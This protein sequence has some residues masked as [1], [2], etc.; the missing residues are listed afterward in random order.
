[1]ELP[2]SEHVPVLTGIPEDLT[3]IVFGPPK[4]GKTTFAASFPNS[5]VVECEPGGAKYVKGRIL[6]VKNLAE[7]REA[8]AIVKANPGYCETVVID[9]IDQVAAWIEAEICQE[10]GLKN[11]LDSKKGEKH[12][13]QWGEY[14]DR[15]LSLLSAWKM[16]GKR[17]VYLAHVKKAE[18]DGNALVINPKTI[19]LYG[20][21]AARVISIVENIGHMYAREDSNG[22]SRILSF[23]PG[24]AIEAG[25][26]HP[27]L[28]NKLITIPA[29][30]PYGPFAALFG[31]NG[32]ETKESKTNG[33]KAAV[34]AGRTA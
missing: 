1:M 34:A 6:N 9:S 2:K 30:D 29:E 5:L 31:G 12:G 8:W 16:L 18:M 23:A 32:K 10:M 15:I 24:V 21:T 14:L 11:I 22:V 26:R 3:M 20:Q 27:A 25:A 33:K 28:A 13:A 7:L 19:N 4:V 17:V